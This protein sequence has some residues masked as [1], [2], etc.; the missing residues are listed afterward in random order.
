MLDFDTLQVASIS[1]RLAFA[2]VF[3][4]T[5]LRNPREI[6]FGV[7]A[8]ALCSSL[9]ASFLMV[10]DP[11]GIPLNAVKGSVV[12]VLYGASLALSW[13]G[14][15]LFY[16]RP[17]RIP[18]VVAL[19]LGSG[20]PYGILLGA[21]ASVAWGLTTVF[22]GIALSTALCIFEIL[23]TPASIRLWTQ[24][25]VLL[26]FGGYLFVFLLTIGVIHFA[27]ERLASPEQGVYALLFDLWCGVF[28]QVGYLAM[29][30]ERAQLKLSR[31]AETDP[32][33]GLANRRGLFA[34]M[35]R[36]A[37]RMPA[38][39]RCAILLADIDHFK[40]INDTHGHEGGDAV[41]IGF[42]ERLRNVMRKDDVI[43]RWGG[44]EFLIVLDQADSIAAIAVAERLRRTAAG[45]PFAVNGAAVTVTAS[46]GVSV[47]AVGEGGIE[48]ALSRADAALYVA[49][50]DGRNR[51]CLDRPSGPPQPDSRSAR[52]EPPC[53]CRGVMDA[54]P[55]GG[56]PRSELA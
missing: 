11:P 10:A 29:V 51:V 16:G 7:W 15:R 54:V 41:L 8:G 49:K 12:Y 56:Q 20:L 22:G 53:G 2:L 34:A 24:Y 55:I 23:R 6:Y 25:I 37:G 40:S 30:N 50:R 9:T 48:P 19:A 17:A 14:L 3:F 36:R 31:L 46:I 47:V 27:S 28:I 1:S 33:T 45:Q 4:V 44:E 52:A 39:P 26:G 38:P 5:L 43:A 18:Q 35:R 13:A 32:L 42:A 21:G